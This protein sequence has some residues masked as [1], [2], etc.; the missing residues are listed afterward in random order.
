M[1]GIVNFTL[2]RAEIFFLFTS[3]LDL[4][5]GAELIDWKHFLSFEIWL[6]GIL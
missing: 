1:L 6:F 3:I 5:S 4:F 2:L